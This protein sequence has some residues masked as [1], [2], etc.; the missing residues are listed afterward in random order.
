MND[1]DWHTLLDRY[2]AIPERL[3]RAL[4]RIGNAHIDD[5]PAQGGWPAHEVID[6]VRACNMLETPRLEWMIVHACVHDCVPV[7]GIDIVP[8]TAIICAETPD[9]PRALAQFAVLREGLVSSLRHLPQDAQQHT[10]QHEEYGSIALVDI[11]KHSVSHEED[12][13]AQL[14]ALARPHQT[15]TPRS[16]QT[17]Y[18][19]I[20]ER[21]AEHFFDELD[22]KP[23]DRRMLDWLVERVGSSGTICDLGC[24]PGQIARY[25][26][27]H[28]ARVRGID[29]SEEMLKAARARKPGL[30]FEQG[31]MLAL[32]S[33]ADGA[34]AGVAAFY[35]IVNLSRHELTLALAEL[36]RVLRPGAWLLI[37]FHVGDETRHLDEFLDRPVTLDFT[38]FT[39]LAMK[40]MLSATGFEITEVIVRDPYSGVE[41]PS[42]RAYVFARTRP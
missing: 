29:L 2:S 39:T 36:K 26:Q 31:N 9:V 21:Y 38:F 32:V 5:V 4:D 34:F 25:L 19:A 11:V 18:D 22:H 24:G 28:G 17:S 8:L 23:F 13:C 7:P 27:A 40:S 14:E 42:Q 12:H 15:Q 6:H 1:M 41:H 35:A 16:V 10:L 20:A 3:G 33:V 37:A 30:T